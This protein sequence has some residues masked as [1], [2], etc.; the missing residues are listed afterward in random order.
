MHRERLR[1]L[2]E[3]LSL[4]SEMP[5]ELELLPG[6]ANNKAYKLSLADKQYL[7][8]D[9]FHHPEDKRDRLGAEFRFSSFCYE[10]G[11][12]AL[13]RPYAADFKEH[14][15]LYE[16]IDGRKL[17]PEEVDSSAVQQA[18][19]FIL[20]INKHRTQAGAKELSNGS[21][22]CFSLS[23]HLELVER[24]IK[25]LCLLE[26]QSELDEQAR[27]LVFT[28]LVPTWIE[29]QDIVM[30]KSRVD[31][32]QELPLAERLIS[33]SDFGFHN[34][35]LSEAQGLMFIDF[36]YAGWDDPAKLVCDFFSQPALPVPAEL[37][38]HFVSSLEQGMTLG[39]EFPERVSL[40]FAAYRLKWACIVL[41]DF[42]PVD[43]ARREF[44]KNE[45][46]S[47][48]LS[49]LEKARVFLNLVQAE[50]RC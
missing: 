38:E 16:F 44:A 25:R 19:D 3:D 8:K 18:L 32:N 39:S 21:E 34:A 10:Q 13:P 43:R 31:L 29:V 20:S 40:L 50:L 24:R 37:L 22:A 41:N 33:P 47:R 23:A 48:K 9:Y 1:K 6:G 17:K 4:S 30:S 28:E 7:L 27:R 42:L 46:E 14:L 2:L 35:L 15:G 11:V 36:E 5:Q 49:Q 45:S 12:R 26:P